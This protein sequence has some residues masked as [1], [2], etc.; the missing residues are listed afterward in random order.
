MGLLQKGLKYNIHA[1]RE[2]WI[3]ILALEAETSVTQ[4]L[5]ND[6]DVYKKLIAERIDNLHKQNPA[7][8]HPEAK[9]IR[10]IQRKLKEH[11]A[12]V[13]RA[14]KGNTLVILPTHQYETKLQDFIKNND[15]HTRATNPTKTFQTQIRST[16]KQSPS[17]A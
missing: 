13:T 1:K 10:S 11:N 7:H 16:I 5:P 6:R 3:Q 15:F 14:D 8:T 12:K 17:R 2:N 4:L 9:T